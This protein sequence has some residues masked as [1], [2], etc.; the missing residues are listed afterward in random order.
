[1]PKLIAYAYGNNPGTSADMLMQFLQFHVFHY[2]DRLLIVTGFNG[3]DTGRNWQAIQTQIKQDIST[4]AKS[5]GMMISFDGANLNAYLLHVNYHNLERIY[6]M[7]HGRILDLSNR[8]PFNAFIGSMGD[9]H[10]QVMNAMADAC[11]QFPGMTIWFAFGNQ[12]RTMTR[13]VTDG[14][15]DPLPSDLPR[16]ILYNHKL[17]SN[18]YYDMHQFIEQMNVLLRT[19]EYDAVRTLIYAKYGLIE[20][21]NHVHRIRQ[22]WLA[23]ID[24]LRCWHNFMHNNAF[25]KFDQLFVL[26]GR[27]TPPALVELLR[28]VRR[29]LE[30]LKTQYNQ[31]ELMAQLNA[32]NDANLSIVVTQYCEWLQ[33]NNKHGYELVFDKYLNAIRCMD[34]VRYD[35][36]S[37]RLN[38]VLEMLASMRLLLNYGIVTSNMLD[39]EKCRLLNRNPP[40]RDGIT[41][42][43]RRELYTMLEIVSNG[44]DALWLAYKQLG[45]NAQSHVETPLELSVRKRHR[46]YLVHGNS[47]L[48]EFDCQEFAHMLA[49]LLESV[50]GGAID[51]DALKMPAVQLEI[52]FDTDGQVSPMGWSIR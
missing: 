1:M 24:G 34:Q 5:L 44:K 30:I 47:V 28:H 31:L 25:Q 43:S 40:I 51:F 49:T 2:S 29:H 46:S 36:A 52:T 8:H 4:T 42:V 11:Q 41:S 7:V 27:S 6:S 13:I 19:H 16:L 50:V 22:Q 35:D 39:M 3:E 23:L 33:A 32:N 10:P 12:S 38:S 14:E 20:L 18:I 26:C 17:A 15:S 37:V 21:S 48:P 9:G 45:G